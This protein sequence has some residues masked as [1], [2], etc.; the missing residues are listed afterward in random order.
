MHDNWGE[1]HDE[2]QKM[3]GKMF[4]GSGKTDV[5]VWVPMEGM[6]PQEEGRKAL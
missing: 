5:Q 6:K 2:F 3:V 4:R 1:T